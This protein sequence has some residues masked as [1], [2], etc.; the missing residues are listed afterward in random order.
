M[1]ETP[2]PRKKRI[3]RI[4]IAWKRDNWFKAVW[5]IAVRRRPKP[6]MPAFAY[7]EFKS[8]SV[9]GVRGII[10]RRIIV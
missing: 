9:F 8:S 1:G 3:C 5:M 4:K 2:V 6:E 7:K 10:A